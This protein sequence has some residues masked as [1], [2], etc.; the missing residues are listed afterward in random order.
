MFC[1]DESITLD[2]PGFAVRD[3][4]EALLQKVLKARAQFFAREQ[5][6]GFRL[7]SHIE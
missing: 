5:D 1:N 2:L 4:M 3:E 6:A 7:G